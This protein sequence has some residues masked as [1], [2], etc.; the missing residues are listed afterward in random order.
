LASFLPEDIAVDID[1]AAEDPSQ[2]IFGLV[3]GPAMIGTSDVRGL[4]CPAFG[5]Y[6]RAC[7]WRYYEWCMGGF[8]RVAA[9]RFSWLGLRQAIVRF[10]GSN[11]LRGLCGDALFFA[12]GHPNR[13]RARLPTADPH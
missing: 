7:R 5:V 8:F 3:D 10:C 9:P 1:N 2:S 4:F 11:G 12:T 13:N 6:D